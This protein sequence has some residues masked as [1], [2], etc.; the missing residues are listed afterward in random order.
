MWIELKDI[1]M[2][3][4]LDSE[5]LYAS[6]GSGSKKNK[7]INCQCNQITTWGSLANI[8]EKRF[9]HITEQGL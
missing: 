9:L 7:N 1:P 6:T 8:W 4:M 5:L 2:K 3:M